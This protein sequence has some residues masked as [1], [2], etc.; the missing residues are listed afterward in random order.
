MKVL[1]LNLQDNLYFIEERLSWICEIIQR[2]A[3]DVVFIDGIPFHETMIHS[4]DDFMYTLNAYQFRISSYKYPFF[5]CIGIK[6]NTRI[7]ICESKYKLFL[8]DTQ[9][10][11]YG[12]FYVKLQY[13]KETYIVSTCVT[14]HLK[15]NG[16]N[17]LKC[18]LDYLSNKN[19]CKIILGIDTYCTEEIFIFQHKK[20]R[21]AWIE[22]GKKSQEKYTIDGSINDKN[23]KNMKK[24]KQRVFYIGFDRCDYFK[25]VGKDKVMKEHGTYTN[26]LFHFGIECNL[27][28]QKQDE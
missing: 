5:S 23:K 4:I 24:R 16:Y 15:S 11:D 13:D 3:Y 14:D 17:Q 28:N 1:S 7:K 18:I 27:T 8:D 20:W 19:N 25:L 6:K 9:K 21:D 22:N 26:P 12:L 2:K 10:K